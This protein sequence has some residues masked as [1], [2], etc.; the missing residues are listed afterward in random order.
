LKFQREVSSH[1]NDPNF[2]SSHPLSHIPFSSILFAR[3]IVFPHPFLSSLSF[4][5]EQLGNYFSELG[6]TEQRLSGKWLLALASTV[7]FRSDFRGKHDRILLS[8]YS[9]GRAT[10]TLSS[11][12][13]EEYEPYYIVTL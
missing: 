8:H 7:I 3:S 10:V 12:S 9:D 5:L 6:V 4:S 13:N 11:N 2:V 1:I